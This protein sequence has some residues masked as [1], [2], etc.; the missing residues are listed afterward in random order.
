MGRAPRRRGRRTD[1]ELFLAALTEL[2]EQGQRLVSNQALRE[3]LV[4]EPQKYL[5]IKEQLSSEN[6][7]VI[8][9]GRGGSVGLA[10]A[11]G[12]PALNLFISY[13]H[14][15]ETAKD[16]ILKHIQPLQRMKLIEEWHDRQIMPGEEWG[17]RISDRLNAA[18][19]IL[20]IISIEFIN[21]KYCYDIEMERAMER[22]EE[23]SARVIPII[24]RNCI[25]QYAPFAKLQALPRDAKPVCSW[26][27]LDDA[28]VDVTEGIKKVA[29]E[30]LGT[31]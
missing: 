21:S 7:L 3:R 14:G 13:S 25:W 5:R 23:G 29:E 31:R 9:R 20:L 11:P 12:T 2:S 4:W 8:G 22:H 27:N 6:V 18:D 28:F 17:N 15:D 16:E 24:Y 1:K 10:S 30:L 19:I 26:G